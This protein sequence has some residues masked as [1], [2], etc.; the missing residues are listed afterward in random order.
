[1]FRC[2]PFEGIV[3]STKLISWFLSLL[4]VQNVATL[5]PHCFQIEYVSIFNPIYELLVVC[6]NMA[7][8]LNLV[9]S[10]ER[11]LKIVIW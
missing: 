7:R 3:E 4:Y 6:K 8:L 2:F 11:W 1:M 5:I 9:S 10:D